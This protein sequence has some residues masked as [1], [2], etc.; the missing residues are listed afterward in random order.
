MLFS[1][2]FKFAGVLFEYFLRTK[3]ILKGCPIKFFD[4]IVVRGNAA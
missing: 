1:G 3:K 4:K 2:G